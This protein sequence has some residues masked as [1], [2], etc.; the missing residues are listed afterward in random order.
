MCAIRHLGNMNAREFVVMDVKATSVVCLAL[1]ELWLVAMLVG[2]FVLC[3]TWTA[4]S[5]LAF[6]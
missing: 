5:L 1:G 3:K 6:I 4:T 2:C